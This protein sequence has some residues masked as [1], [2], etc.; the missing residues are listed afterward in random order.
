M[1]TEVLFSGQQRFSLSRIRIALATPF[2]VIFGILIWQVA[3][4]HT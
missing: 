1:K 2:C 3:F 4:G